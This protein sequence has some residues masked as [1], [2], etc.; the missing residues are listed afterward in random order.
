[1]SDLPASLEQLLE[2]GINTG[3]DHEAAW[4]HD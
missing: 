4:F 2:T 3:C 1:M